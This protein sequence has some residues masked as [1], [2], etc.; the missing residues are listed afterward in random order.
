M[1]GVL[2]GIL[3]GAIVSVAVAVG[4][5][6]FL[7]PPSAPR[8]E[9]GMADV[10]AGSGFSQPPVDMVTTLPAA[11]DTA[12]EGG[13]PRV[14]APA[15]AEKSPL[16][17]ASTESAAQPETGAVEQA[18]NAPEAGTEGAEMAAADPE[19]PVLPNPQAALPDAP[20]TETR[21]TISTDPAQPPLPEAETE[22]SAFPEQKADPEQGV[23]AKAAETAKTAEAPAANAPAPTDAM[24][25]PAPSQAPQ[26]A[27]TAAPAAPAAETE[28]ADA[29][30]RTAALPT[31]V[32]Q[33]PRPATP[34][35]EA[36]EAPAPLGQDPAPVAEGRPTIG[37]P[38]VSLITRNDPANDAAPT[39][40][41]ASAPNR[42]KPP[43]EAFAAPFENAENK[44]KMAIV[45]M[46]RGDSPIGLEALSAF[47]YPISFAVDAARPDAGA[48]MKKYRDAGFEVLALTDLPAGA[49]PRDAETALNAAFAALP[50]AVA[51]ME[52]DGNGLQESR[53]V[54]DQVAG[55][56]AQSGHG[57]L[58]FPKGLNT[59]QKLA[60]KEGVPSAA[61]FRDF[62]DK[63]QSADVIR[64]FLDNAAFKASQE[65][66]GVIMVGR[67]RPDTISALLLWGLQDRA[68][69]VALAPVSKLLVAE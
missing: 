69:R 49:Q 61:V 13:A 62:D 18:L 1:R 4:L 5:S 42:G 60:A 52:G 68:A 45:L 67:L 55:I 29:P 65:A 19:A 43:I 16:A 48:A 25:Q 15:E 41:S 32:P 35:A 56:L 27:D 36:G 6:V 63:G 30:R 26:T 11:D 9:A 53:A 24:I 17:E 28:A 3:A 21:L 40:A 31:V 7:G 22:Q 46:D 12:P 50:E 47:P 54:S 59:A 51:V 38:G 39:T 58:L 23:M 33:E 64:R 34:E 37:K 10:P 57:L 66:N 2:G 44:P 14:N 8:P 20:D